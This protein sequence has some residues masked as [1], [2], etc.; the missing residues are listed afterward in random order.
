MLVSVACAKEVQAACR[1][2]KGPIDVSDP[3]LQVRRVRYAEVVCEPLGDV[4]REE[5]P[6]G[7]SAEVGREDAATDAALLRAGSCE[8]V[9]GAVDR[10]RGGV[11]DAGRRWGVGSSEASAVAGGVAE[12]SGRRG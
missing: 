10:G 7:D 1:W 5:W 12:F 4:V 8:P 11:G 2:A 6:P 3:D 9:C